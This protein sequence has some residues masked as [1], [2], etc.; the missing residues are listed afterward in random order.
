MCRSENLDQIQANEKATGFNREDRDNMKDRFGKFKGIELQQA[1]KIVYGEL[2]KSSIIVKKTIKSSA[3]I[4]TTKQD[5]NK[6]L[7]NKPMYQ[8]NK[9]A[10][11][12]G[13]AK[14][15]CCTIF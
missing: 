14:A 13:A 5:E 1:V 3:K 8:N 11:K 12:A 9:N 10:R 15:A 2:G 6:L 4:N 7:L